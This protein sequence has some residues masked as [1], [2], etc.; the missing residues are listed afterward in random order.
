[1][2]NKRI[3]LCAEALGRGTGCAS[4]DFKKGGRESGN[5]KL[6]GSKDILNKHILNGNYLYAI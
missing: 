3:S 5:K 1:M 4:S 6:R 2:S